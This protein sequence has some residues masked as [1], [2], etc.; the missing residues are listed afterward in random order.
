MIWFIFIIVCLYIVT[1]IVSHLID[2]YNFFKKEDNKQ[3]THKKKL[4]G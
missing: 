3:Q 1:G 2:I 4:E